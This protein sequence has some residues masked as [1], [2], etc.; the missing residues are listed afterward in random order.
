MPQALPSPSEPENARAARFAEIFRA[1]LGWMCATLRRLGVA[2]ADLED[3]AHD[4]F[5][6]V[7]RKL[8]TYD[9]SRPLRPW[10]FA[11]AARQARDDRRLARHRV[12]GS[13]DLTGTPSDAP[14]V[15]EVLARL[16]DG[17]LVQAALER[18]DVDKR[19][20]LVAHD[21]EETPMKEIAELLDIPVFT[22]Y[23]RLRA[24]RLELTEIVRRARA[25]RERRSP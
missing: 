17:Q 25:A 13:V 1:E 24:G 19:I 21:I 23:S 10:L 15:D 11:F 6:A 20:V 22:A 3:V 7:Y 14:L 2:P 16:E 18:L 5:L 8:D 4:V 9:P 12:D